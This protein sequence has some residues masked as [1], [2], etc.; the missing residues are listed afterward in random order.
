MSDNTLDKI[1]GQ[2][3]ELLL[4]I[5]P[6]SHILAAIASALIFNQILHGLSPSFFEALQH[7]NFDNSIGLKAG[8]FWGIP[9]TIFG[10][11]FIAT[12]LNIYLIRCGLRFSFRKSGVD[13]RMDE[14]MKKAQLSISSLSQD[15]RASIHRSIEKEL[16][17]RT[18]RYQ[19][20]R[21][22]SEAALS[23]LALIL[24][25]ALL[26]FWTSK[27]WLRL[28]VPD[29][30]I[31]I[32]AAGCGLFLHRESIRY[33]ISSLIPLQI[34]ASSASGEIAFFEGMD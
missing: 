30:L 26:L 25:S 13:K 20:K 14:W 19:A 32:G 4:E 15:E 28:S 7:I 29:C 34:Y 21:M 24:W 12:G 6:A 8:K 3:L 22:L 27:E 16:I 31:A 11:S 1:K 10:A 2:C 5:F 9:L 23:L 17:R 18:R 33:S